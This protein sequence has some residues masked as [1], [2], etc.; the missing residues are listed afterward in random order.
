MIKLEITEV[1]AKLIYRGLQSITSEI[2][3]DP[4]LANI[5][6]DECNSD[7][8]LDSRLMDYINANINP[9]VDQINKQLK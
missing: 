5:N 1:Q 9:I 4:E 2:W 3:D 7:E 8:E 6:E